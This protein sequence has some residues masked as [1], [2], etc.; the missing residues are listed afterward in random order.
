MDELRIPCPS[1]GK[2]LKVR[3]RNLLGRKV[4]CPKCGERF[5]LEEPAPAEEELVEFEMVSTPPAPAQGTSAQWVPDDETAAAESAA[6][7][8]LERPAPMVAPAETEPFVGQDGGVARMKEMRRRNA[9]RRN[10][11]IIVTVLT[12]IAIG[13][14]WGAIASFRNAQEAAR[15]AAEEARRKELAPSEDRLYAKGQKALEHNLKLA[16]AVDP[17]RGEPIDLRYLPA[18]ASMV[19]HLRPA[20]IMKL[21]AG[22]KVLAATNSLRPWFDEKLANNVGN[23]PL[24]KVEELTLCLYVFS[25]TEPPDVA[26]VVRFAGPVKKSDLVAT[27]F[28]NQISEVPE[29][30][31]GGDKAYML[32]EDNTA[33]A[34]CPNNPDYIQD[35]KD[36]TGTGGLSPG[37]PI[38]DVM[39]HTDR[40]RHFTAVLRPSE[41]LTYRE[42]LLDPAALP[43]AT[44][45]VEWMGGQDVDGA[46]WSFHLD[47][48]F[49]SDLKLA[50]ITTAGGA[51][52]KPSVLHED[53]RE[54][55]DQLPHDMLTMIRDY[56]QPKTVGHQ[57]IIGRF[58]AMMKAYSVAT[59][60]GVNDEYVQMTTVIDNQYA[61]PNLATGAMLT[62]FEAQNT[63]FSKTVDPRP[64]RQE[65][66]TVAARLKATKLD[67][68]FDN[69]PL[70]EVLDF[71]AAEAKVNIVIDGDA[72]KDAG[73]TKNMRQKFALGEATGYAVVKQIVDS[74]QEQ[75]SAMCIVVDEASR[76]ATLTTKK[77]AAQKGQKPFPL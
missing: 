28:E 9:K 37:K 62:W 25:K 44:G 35:M 49:Y 19:F 69:T 15:L 43:V 14:T 50:P 36:A 7:G 34:V 72:L 10:V 21:D 48:R 68:D 51:F 53:I 61:A 40:M 64:T 42:V 33:L 31:T 1:C 57:R 17:T 74:Y 12:L 67:A 26:A 65:P 54:N 46:A 75:N 20:D 71:V 55:Y 58:P 45:L 70:Y 32:Q 59:L 5:V 30:W 77:F 38:E 4:K 76:T 41:L 27:V 29:I 3:D 56:M 52:T 24:D 13:G 66:Q 18:G 8:T 22:Q 39:P 47:R 6:V 73:F 23:F 63:D 2:S 16:D 11:T 60:G